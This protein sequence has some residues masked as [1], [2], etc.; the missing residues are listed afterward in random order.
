MERLSPEMGFGTEGVGF[1]VGFEL[2]AGDPLETKQKEQ[3][4]HLHTKYL[5]RSN[6]ACSK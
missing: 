3:F 1:N 2:K 5:N 4:K 6:K